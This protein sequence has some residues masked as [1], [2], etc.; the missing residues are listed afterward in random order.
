MSVSESP[1]ILLVI[2]IKVWFFMEITF[3]TVT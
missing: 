1:Q 2:Y 3:V